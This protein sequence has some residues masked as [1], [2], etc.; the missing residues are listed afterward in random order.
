M[1]CQVPGKNT[2]AYVSCLVGCDDRE[3]AVHVAAVEQAA[4]EQALVRF[5][6]LR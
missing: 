4:A 6:G 1:G 2:C 3:P 5:G